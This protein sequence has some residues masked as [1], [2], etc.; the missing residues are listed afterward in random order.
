MIFSLEL[1]SLRITINISFILIFCRILF[2][3]FLH[4]LLFH[5]FSFFCL[6]DITISCS[7]GEITTEELERI[8]TIIQNPRQYKIPDWFLN[9][10]KDIKDGKYTQVLS[11]GLDNK[12]REDLELVSITKLGEREWFFL[13]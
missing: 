1:H 7:A 5:Y 10:Q 13:F 9:R 8:V 12:L 11:N 6:T 4:I 2:A 3:D